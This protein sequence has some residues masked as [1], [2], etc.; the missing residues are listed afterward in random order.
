MEFP[1]SYGTAYVGYN[2]SGMNLIDAMVG[3]INVAYIKP[4]E[5]NY[6]SYIVSSFFS[7][8]EK[9]GWGGVDALAVSNLECG[10]DKTGRRWCQHRVDR[11]SMGE[12]GL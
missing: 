3:D 2:D 4:I 7:I 12:A 10:M 11:E 8:N 6:A 1:S 5:V 9:R